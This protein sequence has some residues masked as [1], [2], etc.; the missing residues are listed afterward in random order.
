MCGIAGIYGVDACKESRR[1]EIQNMIA[2]IQHRG[3]D[4]WGYYLSP[5][6]ALGHARLSIVD[7]TTGDQ[8]LMSENLIISFNG[9]VYNYIEIRKD[10][11]KKGIQFVT[12]SDTEVILKAF[13]YYGENCF[14]RFNGQFAILI[15]DKQKQELIIA[16]DRF[17]IRPLYILEHR[18]KIYFSSELKAFDSLND[19]SREFDVERLFE[20]CL[21]WNT[22]GDHTIYQRIKSLP[23]GSFARYKDGVKLTEQKYYE[24]GEKPHAAQRSSKDI[25]EEFQYLLHDAV[26]LR[27]RSDV[28]VGAYLS[29]GIDSSVITHLV[30]KTTLQQFKTFSIAFDDK[31]FDESTY[32]D[33]MVKQINSDHYSLRINHQNIDEHFPEAIYHTDRPVFRTAAVPLYLLS[34]KVRECDLKVV[35]TGEGADEVL[36]G[37][38]SFKEVKLLDFWSKYPESDW[39]PQL[40]KKLYPHL[41]HFSDER[42]YGMM[43][44]YYEGFLGKV[45]NKLASTNIR[46]NNNKIIKNYFNRD[47][48]LKYDEKYMIDNISSILP[49]NYDSW[50]LLQQNQFLEI[51]TLLAGYLLS[52]QGDRMSLAHGV[53][54]RYPFLDHRL[55]DYLFGINEKFKL[56]GF[57]QKYLL[58]KSFKNQIPSSIL[59]RPKR[60]YMSPD[61]RSFI[62]NG[63]LTENSAFFLSKEMIN[64]YGLFDY[65]FLKRFLDKFQDGIPANIGYRDNMV[66]TFILSTQIANYWAKNPR[67]K[68]LAEE[69]L[70]VCLDDY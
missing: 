26:S 69:D 68:V 4:A 30:N 20:H 9:E 61:L 66:I 54:G 44:M 8:P 60:P 12:T 13:A 34:E 36:W 2:S 7:L 49:S 31:E 19:Y 53:E 1:S 45:N 41:N 46:I 59:N 40:I 28:P 11:E 22:Y 58:T 16:R 42:Q 24:L 14:K 55:V 64:D 39:R 48:Q 65:R 67:V 18:Q 47:Y 37:Y 56:N 23:G 50:S 27:L 62:V 15:W 57:S 5:E 35:L 21:L 32:Q 70:K 38:D 52:S 10:L 51:K 29:G 17:G 6:I 43:K 25:E 63:K 33:D 3:P